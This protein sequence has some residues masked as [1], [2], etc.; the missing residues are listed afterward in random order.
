MCHPCV[1]SDIGPSVSKRQ[2]TEEDG[3]VPATERD[4][5]FGVP[6]ERRDAT[7]KLNFLSEFELSLSLK[8]KWATSLAKLFPD[9]ELLFKE[10]KTHQM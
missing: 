8:A 1:T 2:R 5:D 7:V 6:E 3:V 10:G 9:Y 4:M